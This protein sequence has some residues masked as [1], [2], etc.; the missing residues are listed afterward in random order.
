[1][2]HRKVVNGY[3]DN[4]EYEA[5]VVIV[6]KIK[7]ASSEACF[8]GPG[9]FISFLKFRLATYLKSH[10]FIVI[11]VAAYVIKYKSC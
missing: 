11:I 3:S 8:F 7:V 6:C 4:I 2:T 5:F 9:I 1:M 10:I